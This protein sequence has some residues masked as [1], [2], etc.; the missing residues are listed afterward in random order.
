MS[1]AVSL[2]TRVHSSFESCEEIEAY[3]LSLTL[4]EFLELK[5]LKKDLEALLKK[6][7]HNFLSFSLAWNK[8]CF[9]SLEDPD[10]LYKISRRPLIESNSSINFNSIF[11]LTNPLTIFSAQGFYFEAYEEE[12]RI[13][14]SSKVISWDTLQL[15]ENKLKR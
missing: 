12:T 15:I 14:W 7:P 13:K 11:S 9:V 8:G 3:V 1:R 10:L 4:H 5:K 2:L 6:H